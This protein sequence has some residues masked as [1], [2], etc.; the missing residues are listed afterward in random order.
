MATVEFYSKGQVDAKIPSAAQLVPSTSGATSGDVLTFDGSSVGWAAGGG[1]GGGDGWEEIDLSSIPA[2][3]QNGDKVKIAIG[4]HFGAV[5]PSSWTDAIS[6]PAYYYNFVPSRWGTKDS[7]IE[8]EYYPLADNSN[9]SSGT[10]DPIAIQINA[11][12]IAM[13]VVANVGSINNFNDTSLTTRTLF[14]LKMAY[15]NGSSSKT[16]YIDVSR[17]NITTYI[18]KMW[19]KKA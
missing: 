17:S 2:D 15:F 13:M 18:A 1:G 9:N 16:S 6:D 7:I 19:R 4:G 3:W 10:N 14:R 8:G 5:A 11:A 12:Y